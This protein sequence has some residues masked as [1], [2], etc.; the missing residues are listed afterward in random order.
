MEVLVKDMHYIQ[1]NCIKVCL[2]YQK[3]KNKTKES[4]PTQEN[5][6]LDGGIQAVS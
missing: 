6:C 4:H 2:L 1:Y 3:P 5:G